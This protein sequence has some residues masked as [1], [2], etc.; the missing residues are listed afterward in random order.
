VIYSFSLA[1]AVIGAILTINGY[2][3]LFQL[4]FMHG[5]GH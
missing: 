1:L 2:F 3:M 4:P 5:G